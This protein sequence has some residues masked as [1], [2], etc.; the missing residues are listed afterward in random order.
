MNAMAQQMSRGQDLLGS[1]IAWE[2]KGIKL[3]YHKLV[4][5][6]SEAGLDE[7]VV[8]TKLPAQ[9]F[10]RAVKEL[11]DQRVVDKLDENP[12]DITFQFTR[13]YRENGEF[14]YIREFIMS[15]SKITGKIY[16]AD[17]PDMAAQV[18]ALVGEA[19]DTYTGA[20]VA[21]Y[22][23]QLFKEYADIFS[24]PQDGGVYLVPAA[25]ESFVDQVGVFVESIG[26]KWNRLPIARGTEYGDKAFRETISGQI[27][28]TIAEHVKAVE[29]LTP[30]NQ[31]RSFESQARHINDTRYKVEVYASYLGAEAERL[32]QVVKD[33][34][35]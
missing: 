27:E 17:D 5:A 33:A 31:T 24:F 2:M 12:T 13:R 30:D 21:K 19:M 9:A 23:R 22:L 8:R 32:L 28:R 15:M 14:E 20:D 7:D 11:T 4:T 10:T 34:K 6:M 35:D 1:M 25:Y 26:G 18:E 16:C 3:S 29:A